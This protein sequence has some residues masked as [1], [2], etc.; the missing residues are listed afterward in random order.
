M[1]LQL[2]IHAVIVE[3]YAIISAGHDAVDQEKLG[4]VHTAIGF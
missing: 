2:N 3:N 4:R 1:E